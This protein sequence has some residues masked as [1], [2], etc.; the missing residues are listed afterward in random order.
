MHLNAKQL[1]TLGL[2]FLITLVV[3]FFHLEILQQM[4]HLFPPYSEYSNN[5]LNTKVGVYLK[6]EEQSKKYK[7]IEK[8][9]KYRKLNI[10]WIARDV[11]YLKQNTTVRKKVFKRAKNSFTYKLDM[12][13]PKRKVAVINGVIV[14]EGT[15]IAGARV[16]RIEKTRVQIRDYKGF[17]WL[18]LF[19]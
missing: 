3:Y 11:L 19:Q 4:H 6:I 17:K 16:M 8:K 9:L 15:K 7:E 18:T 12:I 10:G 5:N 13:Y 14:H 1:M 2:P